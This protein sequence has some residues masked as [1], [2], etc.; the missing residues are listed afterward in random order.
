MPSTMTS[1][2]RRHLPRVG[3]ARRVAPIMVGT[4]GSALAL[5]QTEYVLQRLRARWP[6]ERFDVREV[7]TRGDRTQPLQV[8]LPQLGDKA[9][10]IAEL[11]Q[12]L[13]AGELD[14][15]VQPMNDRALVEAEGAT[16][17]GRL[18]AAVHS[19]EGLPGQVEARLLIP[20]LPQREDARDALV[21]RRGTRPGE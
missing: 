4:R 3:D 20:P 12:A 19:F 11:E 5:W 18:D 15:A 14:V 6:G 13:L 7:T 1:P 2:P 17:G 16:A 8:P 9:M 10:F 21:A